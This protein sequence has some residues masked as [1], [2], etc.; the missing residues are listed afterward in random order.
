MAIYPVSYSTFDGSTWCGINT[1]H[2][3]APYSKKQNGIPVRLSGGLNDTLYLFFVSAPI[4]GR[5]IDPPRVI[6]YICTS[7]DSADQGLS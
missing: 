3:T 5:S 7:M 2:A 4:D 6:Y 1:L